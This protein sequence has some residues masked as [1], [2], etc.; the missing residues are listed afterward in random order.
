MKSKEHLD[1][2]RSL[3]EHDQ[4]KERLGELLEAGGITYQTPLELAQDDG[5]ALGKWMRGPGQA[6]LKSLAF[7]ELKAC[8]LRLHQCAAQVASLALYGDKASSTTLFRG[9][10]K[11]HLR[12]CG[13][14]LQ[15]FEHTL[16]A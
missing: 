1:I 8:H 4:L 13:Q 16:K 7:S 15:N 3:A 9:P 5:C 12:R 11:A 10:F 6:H 14:S 2:E